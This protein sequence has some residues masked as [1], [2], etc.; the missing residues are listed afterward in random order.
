MRAIINCLLLVLVFSNCSSGDDKRNHEVKKDFIELVDRKGNNVVLDTIPDRVVCLF[1][2]SIDVMYML[3]VEDKLVGINAE[4][5]F[6]KELFDYYKH[7]DSRIAQK[8]LA[9]PG[10]NEMLNIESLIALKP[11][12]L[13]AQNLSPSVIK[14]LSDM[15]IAVYLASAESYD[16]LMQ[17]M[18]DL[19]LL[20]GTKE[21]GEE[22]I[23]YAKDRVEDLARNA[24]LKTTEGK[25]TAYFSWANGKI[26]STAG[27]KSM[28][29]D[30]LELA[31][32]E[33]VC[34]TDIDKPNINPET[35]IEWNPDMIVMWND[36]P[37][38]FYNKKELGTIKAIA[39]KQIFNLVPMFYYNPHTF[40][41]LCTATMINGWAYPN[42]DINPKD[43]VK[44]I[45][46]TLY[47][48]QNGRKLLKYYL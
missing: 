9:T 36:S 38:L 31:G 34:P 29:N 8:E 28:M 5:Y 25:K 17:E 3:G 4:T 26:F 47:G 16:D 24:K 13:I 18:K 22:L 11:Q 27:R 42:P 46:L 6:D 23:A 33:N 39:D 41:S 21:R 30:C 1:D 14:I 32:V 43:E 2:P 7:I 10:S 48:E 44:E 35:L 15:G 12:L 20:L 37:N 19:S 40:K 45:I